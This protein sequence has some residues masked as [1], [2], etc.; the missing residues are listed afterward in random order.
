MGPHTRSSAAVAEG[1][2]AFLR[3]HA[4]V[5][6]KGRTLGIPI[7]GTIDLHHA[8]K[9][10]LWEA[11]QPHVNG[12]FG[13]KRASGPALVDMQVLAGGHGHDQPLALTYSG[14]HVRF[15]SPR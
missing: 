5:V 9:E 7:L 2:P 1:I 10:V 12:R 6:A 11:T 3:Q 4:V 15:S 8:Q 14:S 13:T